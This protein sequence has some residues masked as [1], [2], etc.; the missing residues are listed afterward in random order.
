[1]MGKV[2]PVSPRTL[3]NR[4]WSAVVFRL[5][6]IFS[7]WQGP[8]PLLHRHDIGEPGLTSHLSRY[9]AGQSA[10]IDLGWHW[11][12]YFPETGDPNR[13]ADSQEPS[14]LRLPRVLTSDVSFSTL[15]ALSSH[16][17]GGQ[18]LSGALTSSKVTH[19]C[20]VTLSRRHNYLTTFD[21]AHVP[22]E[23]LCRMSC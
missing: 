7:L 3:L 1:M 2:P 18:E 21:S 15:T 19:R 8:F 6:L 13:P 4:S 10:D 5:L 16:A 20:E 9:H 22:Q 12:L 11:H 23:I 17:L 14:P